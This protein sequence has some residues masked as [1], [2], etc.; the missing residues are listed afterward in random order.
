ME[1][2]DCGGLLVVAW[3]AFDGICWER[4]GDGF[5]GRL[6]GCSGGIGICKLIGALLMMLD[7]YSD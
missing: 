6:S 3:F 7:C 5:G 2:E 4:E 1:L